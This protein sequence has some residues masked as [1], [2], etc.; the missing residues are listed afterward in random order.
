VTLQVLR[1]LLKIW[2]R[3]VKQEVACIKENLEELSYEAREARDNNSNMLAELLAEIQ[4]RD[5]QWD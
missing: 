4:H 3:R 2:L 5:C 1:K